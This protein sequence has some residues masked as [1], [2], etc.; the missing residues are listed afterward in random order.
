MLRTTARGGQPST[1]SELVYR[2]G[3]RVQR[4]LALSV[5][6]RCWEKTREGVLLCPAY[7]PTRIKLLCS[8]GSY[9][10]RRRPPCPPSRCV[11]LS[12]ACV[13]SYPSL[14][15]PSCLCPHRILV[16]PHIPHALNLLLPLLIPAL[17]VKQADTK[18]TSN[19]ASWPCPG[20]K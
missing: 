10:W 20:S 4:V 17:T 3:F 13:H 14:A 1:N 6:G 15:S 18:H 7:P 5:A 16:L 8:A 19:E 11:C 9:I 2:S 12:E